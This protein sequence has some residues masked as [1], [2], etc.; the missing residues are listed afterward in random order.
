M[1][2]ESVEEE[3]CVPFIRFAN[4]VLWSNQ[5][6]LSLRAK[7]L[8]CPLDVKSPVKESLREANFHTKSDGLSQ[9]CRVIHDV[10]GT[11]PDEFLQ[12]ADKSKAL[13]YRETLESIKDLSKA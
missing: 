1:E 13:V 5:H 12:Q 9:H 7:Q 3:L 6:L 8:C 11:L 4:I 10:H 2:K